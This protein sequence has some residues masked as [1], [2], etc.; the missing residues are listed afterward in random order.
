MGRDKYTFQ[1]TLA[2]CRARKGNRETDGF[3]LHY[4]KQGLLKTENLAVEKPFGPHSVCQQAAHAFISHKQWSETPG[5]APVHRA[6]PLQGI[7]S[8]GQALLKEAI[9]LH[10]EGVCG[11]RCLE[12]ETVPV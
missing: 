10:S 7:P 4:E 2:F 8:N 1:H 5:C 9:I 3:G 12:A 11:L 6:Y